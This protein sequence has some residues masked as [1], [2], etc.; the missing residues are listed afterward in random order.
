[1]LAALAVLAA[2]SDVDAALADARGKAAAGDVVAQFSLGAMLYYGTPDT[3]QA[4]DWFRKAAAQQFAPAEFQMGQLYDF[5]FGVAQ[6]DAQALAWYRSA[7][8]HGSAP[9]QRSVGEFYTKGRGVT[10]DS[11]EAMRWFRLGADADD[12]RAQYALGQ[13]YFDGTGVAR[14]YMSAYVWFTIAAGQTPLVDNRKQLIE[15]RNIAAARMTPEQVADAARR[16]AAWKPVARQMEPRGFSRSPA[17]GTPRC[18][19]G[20]SAASG[21]RL[22]SALRGGTVCRSRPPFSAPAP[23]PAGR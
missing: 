6:D 14:D 2:Q 18:P 17:G 21:R 20:L 15:L 11:V 10:A 9:A 4:V 13:S 3:A 7:A 23:D 1:M 5:G 12:L 19:S 22:V 16:V 8:E